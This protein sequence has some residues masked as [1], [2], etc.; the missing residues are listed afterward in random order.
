MFKLRRQRR[1][2]LRLFLFL[3]V[4]MVLRVTEGGNKRMLAI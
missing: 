1:I 3:M 4:R 2:S